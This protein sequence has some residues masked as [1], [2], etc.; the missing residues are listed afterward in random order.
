[1]AF[2]FGNDEL[3]L[4]NEA[5]SGSSDFFS[6]EAG[7]AGDHNHGSNVNGVMMV[8]NPPCGRSLAVN[9]EW[10]RAGGVGRG[11]GHGGIMM[12]ISL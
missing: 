9:S 1:M 6:S 11:R 2:R 3:A 5:G 12:T 8:K 10:T 4:F 7:V